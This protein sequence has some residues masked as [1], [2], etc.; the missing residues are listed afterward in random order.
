MPG[1][2]LHTINRDPSIAICFL[3]FIWLLRLLGALPVGL[4]L[5]LGRSLL[6]K[7]RSL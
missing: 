5:R 1:S 4:W 2:I 6:S 7:G 3:R